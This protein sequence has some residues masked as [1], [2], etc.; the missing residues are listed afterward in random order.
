MVRDLEAANHPPAEGGGRADQHIHPGV[1]GVRGHHGG[2][3]S[4][5]GSHACWYFPHVRARG[6]GHDLHRGPHLGSS[7][8]PRGHH[9]V[10][11][12]QALPVA[13]GACVCGGPV[14]GGDRGVVRARLDLA[15]RGVRGRDVAVGKRRAVAGAGDHHHLR[16]HVRHLRRR[17]RHTSGAWFLPDTTLLIHSKWG[18]FIHSFT[19]NLLH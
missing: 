7:H 16:S 15:S 8:E 11:A 6:G 13:P 9:C 10:C 14:R 18:S 3:T 12:H 2:R 17:H 1:R 19:I 5:R 4:G